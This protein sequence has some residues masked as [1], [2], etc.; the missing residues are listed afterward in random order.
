MSLQQSLY[1]LF[2]VDGQVRGLR[3]RLD[4]AE[5]YLAAQTSLIEDLQQQQQELESRGR[6]IQAKID[7]LEGETAALDERL[8]K[9]RNELNSTSTTKQYTAILT[10]LNTA[11]LAR[12]DIEDRALGEMELID[13]NNEQMAR[14]AEDLA[15]RTKVRSVAEGELKRRNG[16]V[17]ERLA[18]LEAERQ[19]AAEGIPGGDLKVFNEMADAYKGEAMAA[20]EEIDRRHRDYACG[21][22]NI[23]LPFEA[24][25]ALLGSKDV[26]T[27]CPACGRILYLYDETRGALA[28]K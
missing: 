9:L 17:G 5:R 8:E 18:E 28:K 4:S 24:I 20:V 15:E 7:N 26:L 3:S 11:K 25:A 10:E 2:Q 27:R 13:A 1:K 6:Q 12:S 19:V 22:C 16:E 23:H 21:L 14:L